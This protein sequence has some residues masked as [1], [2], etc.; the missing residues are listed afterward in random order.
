MYIVC[1]FGEKLHLAPSLIIDLV[2]ASPKSIACHQIQI[3]VTVH[4][5]EGDGESGVYRGDGVKEDSNEVGMNSVVV[6]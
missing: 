2:L 4:I 6:K 1:C 5:T 3:T